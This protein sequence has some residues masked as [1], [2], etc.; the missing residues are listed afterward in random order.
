VALAL[1][2][3]SQRVAEQDLAGADLLDG[4]RPIGKAIAVLAGGKQPADQLTMQV[5]VKTHPGPL[6][7]VYW[8]AP[9]QTT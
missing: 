9:V 8:S 4:L 5:D 2:G 7:V 1:K 6:R 3:S